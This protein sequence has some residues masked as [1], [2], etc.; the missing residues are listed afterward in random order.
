MLFWAGVSAAALLVVLIAERI[1]WHL[2]VWMGKPL[3]SLG[4]VAAAISGGALEHPYGRAITAGL[5][6]AFA[7]DVLLIPRRR[8]AVFRA[9]VLSFLAGHLAYCAAFAI[10]G[11]DAR[12]LIAAVVV[13]AA[14]AVPIVR[15]LAPHLPRDMRAAA[16]AYV[17]V[18]SLMVATA[19]AAVG[20]GGEG[21]ILIGAIAFYLSDLS[22]A[23][24]RF[25]TPAFYNRLWGLPLYYAAQ[26]VLAATS[27][28]R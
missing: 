26:F 6:L 9:G 10:V 3:A 21:I 24:D 15:W 13:L 25:V 12:W 19:A 27:L 2:G 23:R 8:P 7:G 16:L 5:V 4:F 17:V 11:L 20:A 14:A 28:N 18:I 1:G 22:V